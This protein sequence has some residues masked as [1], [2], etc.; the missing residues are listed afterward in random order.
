MADVLLASYEDI[1]NRAKGAIKP[2]VSGIESLDKLTGGFY[3]GELTVVG[4]RPAVG[5]SA[6]AL[7]LAIS[8]ALLSER[9]IAFQARRWSMCSSACDSRQCL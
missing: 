9:H 6:F 4:A 5:K 7:Q 1:E 2:I 8:G 3:P